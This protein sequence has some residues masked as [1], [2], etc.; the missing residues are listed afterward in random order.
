MARWGVGLNRLCSW[1]HLNVVESEQWATR[2]ATERASLEPPRRK[3]RG[4]KKTRGPCTLL[5]LACAFNL[6]SLSKAPHALIPP[7]SVINKMTTM[8]I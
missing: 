5:D 2:R 1:G 8:P 3:F 6:R 7:S 4:V